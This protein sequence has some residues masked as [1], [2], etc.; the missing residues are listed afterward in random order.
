MCCLNNSFQLKK[1]LRYHY[2]FLERKIEP[3]SGIRSKGGGL[4]FPQDLEK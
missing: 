4:K 1:K 3:P 2:M